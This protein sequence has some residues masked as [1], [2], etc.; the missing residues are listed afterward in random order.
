MSFYGYYDYVTVGEKIAKAKRWM[1][2]QEAS[3]VVL[4][5]IQE[6]SKP[7]RTWWGKAWLD[8]FKNYADFS[9]RV[10]R[11]RTYVTHGFVLDL[12][13]KEGTVRAL[14]AGSNNNPYSIKILIDPLTK[15]EKND[16][17]HTCGQKIES[18]ESLIEG[19]FPSELGEQFLQLLFP[20][21]E[22]IRFA[23]SCPDYAY[24][25]KHVAAVLYGIGVKL[26]DNPS[27]LFELR[28][29]DPSSLIRKSIENRTRELLGNATKKS[30]REIA[31]EDVTRLFGI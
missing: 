16:I 4:H 3:G 26:D 7:G 24:M 14:V 1:K 13:I 23:C 30:S 9:N 28:G 29:I 20:S 10:S 17:I 21:P 25:C 2:K 15:E 27:L 19:R 11:G 12:V 6:R 5:P 8:N 22:A 31:A 18:M